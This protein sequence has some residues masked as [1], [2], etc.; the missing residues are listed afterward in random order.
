MCQEKTK[1]NGAVQ[2]IAFNKIAV[3][4]IQTQPDT[5]HLLF[6]YMLLKILK[7][8]ACFTKTHHLY[9]L[10]YVMILVLKELYL[11][12]RIDLSKSKSYPDSFVISPVI[13]ARHPDIHFSLVTDFR[14]KSS[15]M[16]T[17]SMTYQSPAARKKNQ[18][19]QKHGSSS[20]KQV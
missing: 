4:L 10:F 16:K 5:D 17:V 7:L 6:K 20:P 3:L 1:P 13:S 12:V 11:Q 19:T 18:R 2:I 8:L 14:G 9:S 15:S